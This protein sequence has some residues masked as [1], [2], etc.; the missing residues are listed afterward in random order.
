MSAEQCSQRRV[1]VAAAPGAA[2]FH[3]EP[4]AATVRV[5]ATLCAPGQAIFG[6]RARRAGEQGMAGCQR[7]HETAGKCGVSLL[8]LAVV[9]NSNG[10][11]FIHFMS[12]APGPWHGDDLLISLGPALLQV[13]V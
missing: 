9:R 4:A 2:M 7:A 3:S 10:F 11:F 6:L 1:A 8:V 5:R 12:S 13:R